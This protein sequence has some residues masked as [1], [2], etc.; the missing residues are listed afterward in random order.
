VIPQGER[1][2]RTACPLRCSRHR[3]RVV[4]L[5]FAAVVISIFNVASLQAAKALEQ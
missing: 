3:G 5:Q 2:L 4:R 1:L